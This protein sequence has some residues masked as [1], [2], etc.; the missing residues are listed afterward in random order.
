MQFWIVWQF[1]GGGGGGGQYIIDESCT[2][3]QRV[4]ESEESIINMIYKCSLQQELGL[5]RRRCISLRL[6]GVI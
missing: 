3:K 4:K 1:G 5:R 2:S 6:E